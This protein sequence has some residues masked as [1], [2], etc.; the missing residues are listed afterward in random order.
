MQS[1]PD[2]QEAKIEGELNPFYFEPS[3]YPGIEDML[4][5]HQFNSDNYTSIDLTSLSK[6]GIVIA[7]EM[8][9]Y[10]SK[11]NLSSSALKEVLKTPFHFKFYID[12][13]QKEKSKDCFELGTF[14]HMAFIEPDKFNKFI[15]EPEASLASRDGVMTLV[16]FYEKINKVPVSAASQLENGKIHEMKQY[17][18]TLKDQC[19]YPV[20]AKEYQDIIDVLNFNYKNYGGGIIPKIMKGAMGEVSFYG[21][22]NVTG[23]PVKVR[24][25]SFNIKENIGVDAI[26]SFKTTSAQNV[27]KFLYDTAKFQYELSEGMY[28]KV[29]SD[30]TGRKFN[31][32]ITIMLQTVPPYLPAV[33]WWNAE[34]LANGKYKYRFALDTAKECIDKSQYPGFDALAESGNMGIINLQQPEWTK[35]EIH[36]LDLE[37]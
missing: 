25:D 2:L 27:S 12:H 28:Q 4:S 11:K 31:V 18:D 22:D 1:L 6:K 20:V 15:I 16:K 21:K 36:P 17:L 37:D 32:T 19:P 33:F 8:E 34:D 7:D 13:K 29:V 10:L 30:V 24:T 3:D 5:S 26:I 35:K 14:S 23:L 9:T